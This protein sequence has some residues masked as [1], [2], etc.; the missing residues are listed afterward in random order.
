MADDIANLLNRWAYDIE[1]ILRR[2]LGALRDDL[3]SEDEDKAELAAK[4]AEEILD[5]L[6]PSQKRALS[7]E[8]KLR[9]IRDI[10]M[11]RPAREQL[12]AIERIK[13]STG[14][15]RGRPRSETS[16]HAI[17]ALT[18]HLATPLSW[19]EIALKV[20]GCNH[21]KNR[22]HPDQRSCPP[23]GDAIRDAVGRLETFLRTKGYHPE[24]PRRIRLDR[25]S[26]DDLKRLWQNK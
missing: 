21:H 10:D 18:L 4:A 16:Q 20:K 5:W 7:D 24:F 22:P 3:L 2:A 25:M 8:D 19:R 14:R 23:C 1:G 26:H 11:A 9:L 12:S 17:H 13:R 6:A 15:R